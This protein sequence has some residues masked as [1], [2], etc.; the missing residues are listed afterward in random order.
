MWV[1]LHAL[2]L[3]E[4]HHADKLDWSRAPPSIPPTCAP[5]TAA[6]KRARTPRT[7]AKRAASITVITDAKGPPLAAIVTG[8][9]RNDVTQALPLIDAIAPV[10]GKPG[11]PRRRPKK[12]YADRAYDSQKLR[13]ERRARGITPKI[14]RRRTAH[15]SGLG[16]YRYV[17]EQVQAWLHGFQRLRT[18]ATSAPPSCTKRFCLWPAA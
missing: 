11:R 8:A 6:T 1:A 7:E 10:G 2:L 9:N 15:G 14:A 12:A 3:A 13:A 16:I 5:S 17:A 18:P 4:L